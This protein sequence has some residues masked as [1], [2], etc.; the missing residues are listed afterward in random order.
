M[1]GVIFSAQRIIIEKPV[2]GLGL[3]TIYGLRFYPASTPYDYSPCYWVTSTREEEAPAPVSIFPN[4][5]GSKIWFTLPEGVEA[6]HWQLFGINGAMLREQRATV[7]SE[8]ELS[9]LPA[10]VYQLLILGSDGKRYLGRIVK[11]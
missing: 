5:T 11:H 1:N 7:A 9:G 6:M 4:P 10:G 8:V 3:Q 2:Q